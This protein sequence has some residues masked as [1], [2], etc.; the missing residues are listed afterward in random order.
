V[1]MAPPLLE[2]K[3]LTVQYFG[4]IGGIHDLSLSIS[5]GECVALVGTNGSGKTSALRSFAGFLPGDAARVTG[6]SVFFDGKDITGKSP[7]HI[8]HLGIAT[9]PERD[10]VFVELT[11]MEHFRL[12]RVPRREAR[13]RLERVLE[14]FPDLHP[15]L[16]RRAGYFSG[17]QRQMLAFASALFRTPRVML[18]DEFTQGLSPAAVSVL[19]GV[20]KRLRDEG[21]T[22]I[23]VEQDV[24]LAR[25]LADRIYVLDAGRVV[26]SGTQAELSMSDLARTLLGLSEGTQG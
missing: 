3:E 26:A 10:K 14:L 17:G 16:H 6:G 8:A 22:L 7:Q 11:P 24:A 15:H 21:L 12:A 25:A 19:A 13:E 18:I 4:K 20:V 23:L 5:P 9:V 2:A 1:S